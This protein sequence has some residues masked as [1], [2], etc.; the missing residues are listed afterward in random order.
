MTDLIEIEVYLR[1]ELEITRDFDTADD[2][3]VGFNMGY[4]KALQTVLEHIG[5]MEVEK[6]CKMYTEYHAHNF[7]H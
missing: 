3:E 7:I 4:Q 1:K 6:M 5:D 2:Y